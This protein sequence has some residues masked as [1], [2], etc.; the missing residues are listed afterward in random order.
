MKLSANNCNTLKSNH[1]K[2]TSN[3]DDLTLRDHWLMSFD[4]WS[5]DRIH[6]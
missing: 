3:H 5:G 1:G 2:K 4:G 6:I